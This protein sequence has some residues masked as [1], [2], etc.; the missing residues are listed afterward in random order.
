[1][2]EANAAPVEGAETAPEAA[3]GADAAPVKPDHL[4]DEFWRAD[5]G[6]VD[7]D[8]LWTAYSMRPDEATLRENLS[9][10][11]TSKY[12]AERIANRPETP[13]DYALEIPEMDLPSGVD[14]DLS[15][16]VDDPLVEWWRNTAHE[17]GLNQGQFAEGLKAAAT[18]ELSGIEA[19]RAELSKLGDNAKARLERIDG[20][21]TA[22]LGE[23]T[24]K[25]VASVL[26]TARSVEAFERMVTRITGRMADSARDGARA[27]TRE[28]LSRMLEDPRY[29]TDE[30]YRAEVS[31]EYQRAFPQR[32]A[33]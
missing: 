26:T 13:G 21:L 2:D 32:R 27:K 19:R 7:V 18:A 16:L 8:A 17:L 31:R 24:A 9:A 22:N 20:W 28:E 33:A 23:E 15:K 3:P 10:E 6:E 12:E 29:Q 14:M 1:M 5:P 30:A 25:S 4:P 11:L